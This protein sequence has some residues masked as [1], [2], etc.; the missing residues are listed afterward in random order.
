M[1]SVYHINRGINQPL[2]FRG[3]IGQY[4][5]MLGAGILGL[6]V[7]FAV[8]YIAGVSMR[9]CIVIVFGLG[10]GLFIS[11]RNMSKQYGEHGLMKK[12]ASKKIPKKI[13]CK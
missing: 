12:L 13:K 6:L 3:L 7:L 4:I 5:W 8:L 9:V 2:E 10:I 1:S 11:V